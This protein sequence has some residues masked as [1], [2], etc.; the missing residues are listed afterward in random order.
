MDRLTMNPEYSL[1]AVVRCYLC[2]TPTP[3][4]YCDICRTYLCKN[5]LGEHL[6]NKSKEHKVM[7]FQYR[8]YIPKCLKHSTEIC[9]HFCEQCNIP[10]CAFCVSSGEH[11][12]HNVVDILK[13]IESKKYILQKYLS[14]PPFIDVPKIITE[15]KPEYGILHG[16]FSVSCVSDNDTSIWSCGRDNIIRLYNLQGELVKSIKTK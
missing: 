8:R 2:E 9:E 10:I 15:I 16:L 12:T 11:Q 6:L 4:M 3:P 1:Q 7:L 14:P 5:C 13:S